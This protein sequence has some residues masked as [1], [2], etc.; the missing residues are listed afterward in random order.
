MDADKVQNIVTYTAGAV[1]VFSLIGALYQA[2]NKGNGS[3]AATLAVCFLSCIVVFLPLIQQFSLPGGF[4]ARMRNSV[5]EVK[6][7]EEVVRR[8]AAINARVTYMSI[9]WANR[10]GAPS[11]SEKQ[12]LLDDV[13]KQLR[14]FKVTE[15]ERRQIVQPF[16]Q[17]IGLDFY[18]L[19]SKTL[20]TY[21]AMRFNAL[22]QRRQK[23]DTEQ[24][25]QSEVE[26]SEKITA[27]TARTNDP[28]PFAR[29]VT[30]TLDEEL[31]R[32]M[33]RDGEW[34]NAKEREIA[35]DLRKRIVRMNADCEKKGGY[36][37]PAMKFYE[38]YHDDPES[39]AREVFASAL[40]DIK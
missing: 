10:M 27:W 28:N 7:T 12:S 37:E 18:F 13:D 31:T 30:S 14:E 36:T 3:V 4:E 25:R 35:E 1:A 33:P 22:I 38:R 20:R 34:L 17:M 8:V 23:S 39:L 16:V 6:A 19:Y 15:E 21:A 24:N 5:Q 11:V 40:S 2:M 26:H 9:A 32:F 29:L